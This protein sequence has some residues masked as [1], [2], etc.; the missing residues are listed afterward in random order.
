MKEYF[1]WDNEPTQKATVV[2]FPSL[3]KVSKGTVIICPGGAYGMCSSAEG[4]GIAYFL[5]S[6]GLSVFV[7]NYSVAPS[8]FPQQLL[9][10]RQAVRFVRENAET[11][12]IDTNRVAVMGFSA[13][14]HLAALLCTY[15]GR[16]PGETGNE[17]NFLP[18]AQIL[19]YPVISSDEQISHRLSYSNLLGDLYDEREKYSPELLVDETTPPAFFWHTAEDR[20]VNVMN[21][22]RYAESLRNVC[23]P[24]EMHIF[25]FGTHGLAL[26]PHNPHVSQWMALLREWLRVIG[27]FDTIE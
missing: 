20:C 24:C 23:V 2:F 6:I 10:A 7:L 5:N 15:K 8:H 11:F 12:D 4:E 17:G 21:S 19:C 9:D 25:P 13:G 16:L 3:Q 22:Y 14:G 1:L 27:W 26:A 18:N